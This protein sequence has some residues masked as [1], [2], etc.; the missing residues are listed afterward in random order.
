MEPWAEEQ[1]LESFPKAAIPRRVAEHRVPVLA[2]FCS[3]VAAQAA[4]G[5]ADPAADQVANSY[6]EVASL[7]PEFQVAQVAEPDS[8]WN[9]R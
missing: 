7:S 1:A 6:P 5:S 3:E 2:E 8:S 4:A 9:R